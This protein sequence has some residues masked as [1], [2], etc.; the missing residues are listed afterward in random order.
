MGSRSI[1]KHMAHLLAALIAVIA[2][3]AMANAKTWRVAETQSFR[4]YSAGSEKKLKQLTIKLQQFDQL[5][6]VITD[7]KADTPPDKFD[8]YLVKKSADIRR[9]T[10]LGKNVSGFYRAT[11]T[12]TAAFALRSSSSAGDTSKIW[13]LTSQQVLFHEYAHH[14]ML[15]YFPYPYPP[16]YVEGFAEYVSTAQFK[17][18]VV[19]VGDYSRGRGFA[20]ATQ[21]WLPMETLLSPTRP[22][23]SD[24]QTGL[25]YAQSWLLTHY[26]LRDPERQKKM[27]AFLAKFSTAQTLE[28][29]FK[30]TFNISLKQLAKD[31]RGYMKG[32]GGGMTMSGFDRSSLRDVDVAIATL[33]ASADDVLL[34]EAKLNLGVDS[35]HAEALLEALTKAAEKHGEDL[36]TQRTLAQAQII[37]GTTDA[38]RA[39]LNS[40]AQTHPGDAKTRFLLGLSYFVD[41]RKAPQDSAA[42]ATALQNAKRHF[43]QAYERDSAHYPTLYYYYS[44]LPQPVSLDER[45]TLEEAAFLAP[46]VHEI[47]FDLAKMWAYEGSETETL[48][49]RKILKILSNDPHG[50]PIAVAASAVLKD[51]NSVP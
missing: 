50:G 27:H 19:L 15:R 49:A 12:G 28:A 2:V 26:L 5:L 21:R 35:G 29:D 48:A 9:F 30:A 25:F 36:L 23:L 22:D 33:P 6:R 45:R 44:A 37:F 8:I 51:L 7:L 42:M 43:A 32:R 18:D 41:A 31:L 17:D 24:T 34:L 4:V 39:R 16:W 3:P 13:S 14:F 10:A 46:Q 11:P 1:F 47:R 38:A 40:L 20:I